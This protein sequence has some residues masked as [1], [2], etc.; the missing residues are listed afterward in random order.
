VKIRALVCAGI[1]AAM[2]AAPAG[3]ADTPEDLAQ[4]AAESWL[5]LTDAGDAG[6]SWDQAARFFKAAVTREQW[7]QALA[8]VRPPLG[9]VV[10]RKVMSRRYS[11]KAPGAPD[12]KYVT[13]R[14]ETVFANKA[15]AVETVTPMLDADGI[16]R[17]SGYFIR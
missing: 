11:E 5:K 4:S 7:T 9:K 12:G 2:T 1:V 3:A 10:S 14:Y 6:A 8:G 16:W 17:V 13:I 15:S